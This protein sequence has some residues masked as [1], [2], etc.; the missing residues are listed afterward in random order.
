MP[1]VY[2]PFSQQIFDDPYEIYAHLRREQP[3]YRNAERDFWALMR[4]SDIQPVLRDH[5]TYSNIGGVDLDGADTLI[6]EGNFL[7]EDPPDHDVL[8]KAVQASFSARTVTQLEGFVERRVR[9]L[10][11]ACAQQPDE[12]DLIERLAAPLPLAVICHLLGVP[13]TDQT[14]VMA[15]V[16]RFTSRDVASEHVPERALTAR[17]ELADVFTALARQRRT[18]PHE[19]VLSLL[20]AAEIDGA[21][22]R[23]ET[24]VGI[25]LIIFTAG[26]ETISNL[27]G[28]VVWNLWRHPGQRE[29][30]QSGAVSAEDALEELVRYDA[31]VQNTMRTLLAD[32][33]LLGQ[34]LPRGAR[35]LLVLASA[36]R[37]EARYERPGELDLRREP[38]RHMG[39]GY[40][41]HFCLGAP[42]AR[43]QGRAV[44]RLLCESRLRFDV[45][46][47][48]LRRTKVDARGFARLPVRAVR[49]V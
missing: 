29:L 43:L 16:H 28:N 41:I 23:D 15:L 48:P 11:A 25:V 49:E 31:P 47:E 34:R 39:F 44:L 17:A 26:S 27:L 8:R 42:L 3:L 35:L 24:I 33:E 12:I 30:L 20:A 5:T 10:L 46:G 1:V 45:A 4:A 32:A 18:D 9:D 38:R 14:R 21:R 40:G 2:D 13:P 37:D 22:L 36:N 19:D 6:G 7:D